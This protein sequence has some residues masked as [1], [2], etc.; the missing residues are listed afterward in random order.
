MRISGPR[1]VAP[2]HNAAR[3]GG[4]SGIRFRVSARSRAGRCGTIRENSPG[5]VREWLNRAVSKTVDGVTR[6]W[7][8]I[9]PSPPQFFVQNQGLKTH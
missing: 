1:S 8:R 3:R 2:I 7:V 5:E 9:P 6:P 4:E